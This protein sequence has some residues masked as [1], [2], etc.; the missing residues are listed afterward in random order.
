M[1]LFGRNKKK[2]DDELL[3][4]SSILRKG[5][6]DN[7]TKFMNMCDYSK[8]QPDNSYHA[9]LLSGQKRYLERN[10]RPISQSSI[11]GQSD[12]RAFQGG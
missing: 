9:L 7:V 12:C 5:D 10:M 8:M 1:G 6:W 4:L 2:T 3:D 11:Q